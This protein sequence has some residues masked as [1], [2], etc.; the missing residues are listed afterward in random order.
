MKRRLNT[1][2]FIPFCIEQ[3]NDH[4]TDTSFYLFFSKILVKFTGIQPGKHS[5][6]T[7]SC[8]GSIQLKYNT[9]EMQPSGWKWTIDQQRNISLNKLSVELKVSLLLSSLFQMQCSTKL[10]HNLLT[11]TSNKIIKSLFFFLDHYFEKVQILFMQ[12]LKK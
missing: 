3:C 7:T 9:T 12:T 1:S 8:Q 6:N 2:N 11:N 5:D 4:W 10:K